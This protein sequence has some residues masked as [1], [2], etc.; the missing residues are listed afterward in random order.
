MLALLVVQ[1]SAMASE[2]KARVFQL[3]PLGDDGVRIFATVLDHSNAAVPLEDLN[4]LEVYQ[5]SSGGERIRLEY[6]VDSTPHNANKNKVLPLS[7]SDVGMDVVFIVS[8][9]ADRRRSDALNKSVREAILLMAKQLPS[10]ARAN[11]IWV[12]DT[13]SLFVADPRKS[14][15]LTKLR[16]AQQWCDGHTKN[17]Y[18]NLAENG[19]I[20]AEHPCG[21]QSD[22]SGIESAL[23]ANSA[24]TAFDGFYPVLF[25]LPWRLCSPAA[26]EP[27]ELQD[28]VGQGRDEYV[29]EQ[30]HTGALDLAISMLTR[31]GRPGAIQV[32]IALVDG[33]DGYLLAED[34]CRSQIG[35]DCAKKFAKEDPGECAQRLIKQRL[36]GP[37]QSDFLEKAQRA[38]PLL[39]AKRIRLDAIVLP[40]ALAHETERMS[41][42]SLKSGGTPRVANTEKDII[43]AA[44]ATINEL[45]NAYVVDIFRDDATAQESEDTEKVLL[46]LQV[47]LFDS[48]QD[49]IT[50]QTPSVEFNQKP[51]EG[52]AKKAYAQVHEFLGEKLGAS[53]ANM[54]LRSLM[55][56]L[57]FLFL[58]LGLKILKKL[59]GLL[60]P[61]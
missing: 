58:G 61:G 25:G 46:G 23:K 29:L 39:H 12:T 32:I 3:D 28:L 48:R 6:F 59:L 47:E 18:K 4:S 42:L 56:L 19:S 57:G 52:T 22:R 38:L 60:R 41:L 8:G 7:A 55:L 17:Y 15:E 49:K 16:S 50:V 14:G 21:L 26:A 33:K 2:P 44:E 51:P 37:Q 10:S 40:T 45:T 27:H 20:V 31:Y 11:L 36:Y 54:V 24:S 5:L 43:P 1:S 30:L 13:L 9:N 35:Q 53:T 34:E